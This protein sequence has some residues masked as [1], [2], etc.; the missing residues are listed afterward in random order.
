[1]RGVFLVALIGLTLIMKA[2]H[3]V[4]VGGAGRFGEAKKVHYEAAA[5]KGWLD[6]SEEFA[7]VVAERLT[8]P[9]MPGLAQRIDVAK[10]AKD[11]PTA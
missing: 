2:K 8:Y 9:P 11:A 6:I 1:M 7:G 3:V 10:D 5:G 4:V